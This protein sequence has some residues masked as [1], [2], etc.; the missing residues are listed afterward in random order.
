VVL[1]R[2]KPVVVI[3]GDRFKDSALGTVTVVALTSNTRLAAA[4]GNVVIEA[5]A[6][7]LHDASVVNVSAVATVD[8]TVVEDRIGRVS[9]AQQREI[10]RGLR[11]AL[12][13]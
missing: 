4:P 13:L 3:S 6:C 10:D 2:R 5:G 1:R 11:L 7:G 8:R 9:S 12:G